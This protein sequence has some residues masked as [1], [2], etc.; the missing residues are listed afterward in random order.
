MF[1]DIKIRKIIIINTTG[2]GY[3]GKTFNFSINVSMVKRLKKTNELRTIAAAE[4]LSNSP[5]LV[6]CLL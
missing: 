3:N 6:R 4:M 1:E 2:N 5:N